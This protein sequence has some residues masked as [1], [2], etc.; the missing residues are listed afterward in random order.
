MKNMKIS[1][2][3]P[4]LTPAEMRSMAP[5]SLILSRMAAASSLSSFSPSSRE[6]CI[7]GALFLF[8]SNNP[9]KGQ[10]AKF[11]RNCN[12]ANEPLAFSIFVPYDSCRMYDFLW[13]CSGC[14]S[15]NG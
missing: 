2:S 14:T 5:L 12:F 11:I 6:S 8:F 15:V 13:S 9:S 3:V 7:F 10:P 4:D 1:D